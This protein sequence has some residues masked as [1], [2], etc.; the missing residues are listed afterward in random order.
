[1]PRLARVPYV[2]DAWY[3]VYSRFTGRNVNAKTHPL[4]RML[5][6]QQGIKRTPAYT[7]RG[8]LSAYKD[9]CPVVTPL[10]GF[11]CMQKMAITTG[12]KT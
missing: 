11:I 5:Q 10:R 9:I 6:K 1:M 4:I 2:A 8:Q 12:K 7:N 3:R